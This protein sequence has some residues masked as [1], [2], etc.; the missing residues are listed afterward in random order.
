[1]AAT[2]LDSLRQP[3]LHFALDPTHGSRSNLDPVG[4][5]LLSLELVNHGPLQAG[6]LANHGQAQNM[7]APR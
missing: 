1:M 3:G 2:L 6:C 5:S 4:E 7:D